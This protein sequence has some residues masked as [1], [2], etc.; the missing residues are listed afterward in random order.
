MKDYLDVNQSA[1]TVIEDAG[2]AEDD[3]KVLIS[4]VPGDEPWGFVSFD[5]LPSY[6][7]FIVVCRALTVGLLACTYHL[8]SLL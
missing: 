1:L 7:M 5:A 8:G 4:R 6:I 3:D 2:A